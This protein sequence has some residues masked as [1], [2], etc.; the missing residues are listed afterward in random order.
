MFNRLNK[1]ENSP[2]EGCTDRKPIC[3]SNCNYYISWKE[4]SNALKQKAYA[5]NG[6]II[7]YTRS[8]SKKGRV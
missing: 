3:H 4:R 6:I 5:K 1:Y 8:K 2:C 7:D